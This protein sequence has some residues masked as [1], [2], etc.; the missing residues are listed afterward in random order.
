MLSGRAREGVKHSSGVHWGWLVLVVG[1]HAAGGY[2][3][4][5]S[6]LP[7]RLVQDGPRVDTVIRIS[8]LAASGQ[9]SMPLPAAPTA[10]ELPEPQAGS[11]PDV[12]SPPAPVIAETAQAAMPQPTTPPADSA[13]VEPAP[14]PA[15][16]AAVAR[17]Q[18]P[19]H[20]PP[21][22][23][24]ESSARTPPPPD[25][26]MRPPPPP[27]PPAA[28]APAASAAQPASASLRMHA[29]EQPSARPDTPAPAAPHADPVIGDERPS[30]HAATSA[31]ESAQPVANHVQA[32]HSAQFQAARF[33][34]A[35]LR[36]TPPA[37]PQASRRRGEHGQVV[38]RV[39]V[40]REGR[41][42]QIEIADSSGHP[43][44]DRA[45]R[46]AVA[47]WRFEPAYEG[48]MAVDSWVRVPVDFRLISQ[49]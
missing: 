44:L 42:D 24:V 9:A 23:T 46:E 41:A 48:G 39:R 47:G 38:L 32:Q 15:A 30:S 45:A 10:A 19:E 11:P 34:A 2:A 12:P 29:Q 20:A 33:D 22:S 35:Y 14:A 36:N 6:G 1:A 13:P 25:I 49:D 4:L 18:P 28:V 31:T 43:R 40:T 5:Q 3:V 17:E 27:P 8:L 37:Y 26:T 21:G 7:H 16:P